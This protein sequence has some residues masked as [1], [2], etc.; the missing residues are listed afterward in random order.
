MNEAKNKAVNSLLMRV[1][2]RAD[3]ATPD[4]L[5]KTFVA[6][7]PIPALLDSVDNQIIYGRRGTGKTHL[8]RY[9]AERKKSEGDVALYVDLRTIGATNMYADASQPITVRAT[10]L[11]VDLVEQIHNQLYDLLDAKIFNEMLDEIIPSLDAIGNAATEVKVVG[12]TESAVTVDAG[13]E[14]GDEAEISLGVKGVIP[15]LTA[16]A[17]SRSKRS[18]RF[19]ESRKQSG[20]EVPT[21]YFGPLGRALSSLLNAMKGHH[22][23][24]LLDE[25]SNGVPRD[26]QPYLADLLRRSFFPVQGISVKIA[27]LDHQSDFR[28]NLGKGTQYIGIDLGADTAASLDLDDFLVFHSNTSH[29]RCFFSELIFQHI[30]ILMSDLGYKFTIGTAS[31]L[32]Q[33]A[34]SGTAFDELVRASEGIPR[35]ALQV[36]GAAAA[37]ATDKP[38]TPRNVHV[39]AR[40]YFLRDKEGKISQRA[41]ALLAQIVDDCVKQSSRRLALKRHGESDNAM[42]QELYD[43]RLIHR[44]NSGVILDDDYTIKFDLYLVD[45]GCFINLLARG[46]GYSVSDG[47]DVLRVAESGRIP[48]GGGGGSMIRLRTGTAR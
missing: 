18:K 33:L 36:A 2:H 9:F 41:E 7:D 22:L 27:A 12:S 24:L 39:A 40:N 37:T 13:I 25:W 6:V 10:H 31:E 38:I 8:L 30:S 5:A 14:N 45:F 28:H 32:Q 34:F 29:A 26:L 42:I 4:Y 23:W 20:V 44:I 16:R 17:G 48:Y 43:N 47:T 15:S 35:D 1:A 3:Q 19:S 21:V 11:L 46:E